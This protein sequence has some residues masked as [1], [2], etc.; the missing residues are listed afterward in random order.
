MEWIPQSALLSFIHS[1]SQQLFIEGLLCVRHWL[2]GPIIIIQGD[3]KREIRKSWGEGGLTEVSNAPPH[4]PAQSL[5]LGRSLFL[6]SGLLSSLPAS[7]QVSFAAGMMEVT[8][9]CLSGAPHRGP[10][11]S[12]RCGPRLGGSVTK[13]GPGIPPDP[14]LSWVT[15]GLQ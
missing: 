6:I 7:C 4:S 5:A 8:D 12:W 14:W 1:F 9:S 2:G 3:I 11:P 15:A 13:K 10:F